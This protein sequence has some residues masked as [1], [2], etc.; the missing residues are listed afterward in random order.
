MQSVCACVCVYTSQRII[1]PEETLEI[2]KSVCVGGY[3]PI[4]IFYRFE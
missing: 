1:F 4:W 3:K 2:G